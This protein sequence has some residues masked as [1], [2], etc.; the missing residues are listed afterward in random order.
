MR[1]LED[2]Q[3]ISRRPVRQMV[4]SLSQIL[5]RE[6]AAES[7]QE[8]GR[9]VDADLSTQQRPKKIGFL[10]QEAKP[11]LAIR[12]ESQIC[13]PCV[14]LGH[15]QRLVA[16]H[17]CGLQL[18]LSSKCEVIG[19]VQPFGSAPLKCKWQPPQKAANGA[20]PGESIARSFC[21]LIRIAPSHIL[22][23]V[24]IWNHVN[25]FRLVLQRLDYIL[26]ES[27]PIRSVTE[28]E[29]TDTTASVLESGE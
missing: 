15:L 29:P 23:R 21:F 8:P 24:G 10:A 4:H 3:I 28:F 1:Q 5:R 19:G 20:L 6:A 16:N 2:D 27:L 17:H 13:T 26:K 22:F 14:A 7:Q 9:S 11:R 25:R 18:F 12:N